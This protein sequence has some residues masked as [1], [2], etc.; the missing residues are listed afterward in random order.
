MGRDLQTLFMG[1]PVKGEWVFPGRNG[2]PFR[3]IRKA[4]DT[5]IRKAGIDPGKGT[6]KI[7]FHTLRHSAISQL[8]ECG[9]DTTMVQNY[10]A[11]ASPEMTNNYT[12]LSEEYRRKT[13]ELLD[14]LY[15]V[16]KAIPR[17]GD[18]QKS[19]Q[20]SGESEKQTFL[21]N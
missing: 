5:A 8:I 3:D 19:S 4:L 18:G 13:G 21:S 1:L 12:H 7:V 2:K 15:D 17:I 16:A 14:G 11:H 9:A 6:M 20:K 10:V